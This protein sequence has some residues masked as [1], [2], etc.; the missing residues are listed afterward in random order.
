MNAGSLPTSSGM[1][2]SRFQTSAARL[3]R[4]PERVERTVREQQD[5]SEVLIGWIQLAVVLVF[6]I[7]YAVSPKTFTADAPFRP[8]PWALGAYFLFTLTR[9]ALAWRGSLPG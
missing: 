5:T 1:S 8:V 6:A 4:L 3:H 7:L 2:A 9:L